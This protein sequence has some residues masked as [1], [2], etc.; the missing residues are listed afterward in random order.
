[1]EKIITP[2]VY[3]RQAIFI[4]VFRPFKSDKLP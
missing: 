3:I 4:E 2:T 1:M